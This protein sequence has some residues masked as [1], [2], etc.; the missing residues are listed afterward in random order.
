MRVI[1]ILRMHL[2]N[3]DL[4]LQ[5]SAEATPPTSATDWFGSVPTDTAKVSFL[6][7]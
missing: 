4:V 7:L 3:I 6:S 5:F 1:S 2:F